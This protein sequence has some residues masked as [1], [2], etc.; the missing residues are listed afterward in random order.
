VLALGPAALASV[1]VLRT[2]LGGRTVYSR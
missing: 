1:G 2:V